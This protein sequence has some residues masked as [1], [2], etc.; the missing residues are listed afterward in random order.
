MMSKK[1]IFYCIAILLFSQCKLFRYE[2]VPSKSRNHPGYPNEL[3]KCFGKC[4]ISEQQPEEYVVFTGNEYKEVVDIEFKEIVIQEGYSRIPVYKER[5][6]KIEGILYSKDLMPN[7]H[8]PDFDWTTH[9]RQARLWWQSAPVQRWALNGILFLWAPQPFG[10]SP[11]W[12]SATRNR[13]KQSPPTLSG[14]STSGTKCAWNPSLDWP[15]SS[16]IGIYYASLMQNPAPPPAYRNAG[17]SPGRTST[18]PRRP[19]AA[20]RL[21]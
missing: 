11:V 21:R 16:G 19:S 9:R 8:L 6:D 13:R 3:G 5:L 17:T 1:I 12:L 20:Q 7:L 15:S 2:D 18:A 14:P 4:D 10:R